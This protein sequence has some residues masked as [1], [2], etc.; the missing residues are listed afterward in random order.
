MTGG[1]DRGEA[2][3]AWGLARGSRG[4]FFVPG[5]LPGLRRTVAV[6]A[7]FSVGFD[8]FTPRFLVTAPLLAAIVMSVRGR[9]NATVLDVAMIS[10]PSRRSN[11]TMQT[12]RGAKETRMLGFVYCH[13]GKSAW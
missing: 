4:L 9:L 10:I 7:E 12:K 3:R 11:V 8:F 2:G 6:S 5:G 1:G 13:A